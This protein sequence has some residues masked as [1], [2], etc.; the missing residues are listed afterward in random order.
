MIRSATIRW[1]IIPIFFSASCFAQ[2][3]VNGGLEG[4]VMVDEISVVAPGWSAIP[5]T[6]PICMATSASH[7]TPDL[8]SMTAPDP[9][10]GMVGIPHSGDTFMSG[11][12]CLNSDVNTMFQEGIMQDVSGFQ[13]G[14][15]Y[16][17]SFYQANDKQSP[18]TD[19]SG[20]WVVY[21]EG[22]CLDSTK[23]SI[24]HLHYADINLSWDYRELIFQAT[25]TTHTLKFMPID[26]D[27]YWEWN[28]GELNSS[29]RMGID[30]ILL[31][32]YSCN[33]HFNVTV[34]VIKNSMMADLSDVT[35]QW[36]DCT[37]GY[38]PIPGEINK[39]FVA[40]TPGS[41]AVIVTSEFCADTSDCHEVS[42][43]DIFSTSVSDNEGELMSVEAGNSYQ[44]LTCDDMTPIFGEINQNFIPV[45]NG[46]Y[47][48]IVELNGC[49]D[50]SECQVVNYLGFSAMNETSFT[51][52]PNPSSGTITLR[53]DGV[54]EDA[55]IRVLNC[56]GDVVYRLENQADE[57]S[58][59]DLHHL[60][61]G[62]YI[63][64]L[65]TENSVQRIV[66]VLN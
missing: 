17:I 41:Y 34:S 55:K 66:F 1:I 2:Q 20:C 49:I 61:R 53:F 29:V 58:T 65:R 46:S 57:L 48:V 21:A 12:F 16:K 42:C 6:D 51:F 28:T 52:Y 18:N 23:A 63:L 56:N 47:A 3:F 62:A 8:T 15:L 36:V 30:S 35:Y 39:L 60:L 27:D 9:V 33:E 10:S 45:V 38:A 14:D 19:T 24:N 26:D 59:L 11:V 50:T 4:S 32:S 5:Y 22:T 31:S 37:N 13:V 54:F 40:Q 64:E 43:G 44:W 25:S 7:A